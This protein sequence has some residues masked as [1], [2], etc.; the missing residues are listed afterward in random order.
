MAHLNRKPL[1]AQKP[2]M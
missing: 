2:L 1:Q